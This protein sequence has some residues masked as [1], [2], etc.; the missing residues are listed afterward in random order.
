M[1]ENNK[2]LQD[3]W[4]LFHKEL[5]KVKYAYN[6]EWLG[7]QILK[8]PQDIIALQEIIWE[9][10]PNL[11]IETGVACGGSIMFSA[12]MLIA[13]QA[14]GEISCG[15]V[16]GIEIN[17]Y[18]E[19]KKAILEHPLSKNI[20][21]L[22]G[23]SVDY[24]IRKKVYEIA[25]G[26]RVLIYLDSNHTHEHVLKELILYSELISVGGYIIVE[27]TGIEDLPNW[28]SSNRPWGKGNNPKTAVY[29]FLKQTNEFEI[30]KEIDSKLI[31]TG[32]PDGYL[33]RVK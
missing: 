24:N 4:Q 22:E 28:F 14:C 17:L 29:E 6:F 33:R 18:P 11:I 7:L 10:K 27:D 2:E 3:A 13:L 23:S 19:N 26:K 20:T 25:K 1:Y 9:V 21:L 31:L 30:D 12:T 32:S 5:V 15:H 8:V 16:V